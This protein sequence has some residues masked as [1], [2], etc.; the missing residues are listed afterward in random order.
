M[1]SLVT[2]TASITAASCSVFGV[3]SEETPMYE[4]IQKEA[5]MEIRKYDSYIVAK[6]TVEGDYDQASSRGFRI[7]AAY[8]FGDNQS[9]ASIA[10]TAPVVQQKIKQQTAQK[11]AMTAPV[12]QEKTDSGWTMAFMM[13][14]EYKMDDLPV[15]SDRRIKFE[16][17]PKRYVGAITYSWGRGEARNEQKASELTNWLKV[18]PGYTLAGAPVS[19]GYDPPWTLP[20]FRRNEVLIDLVKANNPSK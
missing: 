14:S 3:R 5:D 1:K 10:M 6:T 4:V 2:V 20:F 13:P 11:I 9:K 8:I 12:V 7:L 16:T 18:Q 17:V 19:A 15:P